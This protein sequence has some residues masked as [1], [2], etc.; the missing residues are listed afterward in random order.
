MNVVVV[1][2]PIPAGT[3]YVPGSA[4][5][6]GAT[7]GVLDGGG[8]LLTADYGATYGDLAPGGVVTLRFQV[9]ITALMGTRVIVDVLGSMVS[10]GTLGKHRDLI[11]KPVSLPMGDYDE[12]RDGKRWT[13]RAKQS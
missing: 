13:T 8:A 5:M 3:T 9:V 6:N 11:D 1:T 2:D 10:N 4:T 12:A 7:A